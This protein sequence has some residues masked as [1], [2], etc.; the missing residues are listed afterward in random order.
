MDTKSVRCLINSI[1]RFIHLVSCQ[2][3]KPMLIQKDCRNMVDLLKVLK[4]VLDEVVNCKIPS[5]VILFKECEELDM[6]VNEAREFVENWSP[7][8]SKIFTV[9]ALPLTQ[10]HS[11]VCQNAIY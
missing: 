4:P 2:S 9:S 5:D 1:S 11:L 8:L 7:K 10:S 3:L 6:A